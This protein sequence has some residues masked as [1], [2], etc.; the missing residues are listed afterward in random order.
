MKSVNPNSTSFLNDPWHN[1]IPIAFKPTYFN[2]SLDLEN[3]RISDLHIN[4][5]WDF[6]KLHTMFGNHLN[7]L[8][9]NDS[10]INVNIPN[11]WVWLPDSKN[12]RHSAKV[13][14]YLN[15]KAAKEHSWEG[16]THLWRLNVAPQAKHFIWVMLKGKIKTLEYLYS[17]NF[18]SP[19]FMPYVWP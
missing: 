5:Y 3:L 9:L 17:L 19:S 7:S 1:E 16:W 6:D 2:M 13:Y 8:F 18:R 14:S 10:A 15:L 4:D 12:L 11:V